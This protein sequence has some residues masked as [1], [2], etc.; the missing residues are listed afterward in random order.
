MLTAE[1]VDTERTAGEVRPSR[2]KTGWNHDAGNHKAGRGGVHGARAAVIARIR[3]PVRPEFAYYAVNHGR[4]GRSNGKC[5]QK[6]DIR[7]GFRFHR[8]IQVESGNR[9]W[10]R[11]QTVET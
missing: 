2:N 9:A 7:D 3:L 8:M 6:Y 10:S 5:R 1:V 4:M 11:S